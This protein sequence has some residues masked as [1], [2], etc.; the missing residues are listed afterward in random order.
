VSQPA[1]TEDRVFLERQEVCVNPKQIA[2]S[3]LNHEG[4]FEHSAERPDFNR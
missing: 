3:T 1:G 4:G 2:F